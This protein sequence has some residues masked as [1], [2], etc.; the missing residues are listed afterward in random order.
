MKLHFQIIWKRG[1][2]LN[3]LFI[4]TILA[5]LL[6]FAIYFGNN[7]SVFTSE[8]ERN[9]LVN[10]NPYIGI[11]R[12]LIIYLIPLFV[13]FA[14]GD[15]GVIERKLYPQIYSKTNSIKYH[16]SK[17]VAAFLV[18]FTTVFYFLLLIMIFM[19]VMIDRSNTMMYQSTSVLL[20]NPMISG[21]GFARLLA[22]YPILHTL[23][24]I[25]F[26]S[27]YGGLASLTSYVLSLFINSKI[28]AYVGPFFFSIII[29]LILNIYGGPFKFWYP[30]HFLDPFL[31]NQ[32]FIGG[33]S[34][35][36]GIFIFFFVYI[37]VLTSL[38]E[39][40][41]KFI[42]KQMNNRTSDN[43]WSKI[44]IS[45][46]TFIVTMIFVLMS[47][48]AVFF[49]KGSDG[50][51]LTDVLFRFPVQFATYPINFSIVMLTIFWIAPEFVLI[52]FGF[53]NFVRFQQR[54]AIYVLTRSK[55]V[56]RN[57]RFIMS[58][59]FLQLFMMKLIRLIVFVMIFRVGVNSVLDQLG[60]F[61]LSMILPLI[62]L[63]LVCIAYLLW[64]DERHILIYITFH[65][66]SIISLVQLK[67][68]LA[69]ILYYNVST[70]SA[71]L[72]NLLCILILIGLFGF[73]TLRAKKVE[74]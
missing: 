14:E 54:M 40:K 32:E 57:L 1:R 29:A 13:T 36:L 30:Q 24:Y 34:G 61:G 43:L 41:T 45:Q 5:V 26:I 3:V 31:T 50:I 33:L 53:H 64:R 7:S 27:I 6:S 51:S 74:Y 39:I 20:N 18:G 65:L 68:G 62:A 47:I 52:A 11:V 15:I 66:L 42:F 21:V 38:I 48:F 69:L 28:L 59:I 23:L 70:N 67:S 60:S 37:L 58:R 25:L 16:R 17:A 55:S 46:T 8:I 49:L 2:L 10:S 44:K 71:L 22:N 4:A 12:M 9:V 35:E 63:E 19:F 72:I 73:M 56:Y